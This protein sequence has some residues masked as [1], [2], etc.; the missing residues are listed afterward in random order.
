MYD[1]IIYQGRNGI[2]LLS[3]HNIYSK[4]NIQIVTCFSMVKTL[5]SKSYNMRV[6]YL[7]M[8]L[9]CNIN[10]SQPVHFRKL[11]SIKN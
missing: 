2:D 11:Y 9:F 6:T 5:N 1:Y 10:P 4:I 7:Y 3:N 8:V